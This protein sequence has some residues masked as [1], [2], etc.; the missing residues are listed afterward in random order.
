MS[1]RPTYRFRLSAAGPVQSIALDMATLQSSVMAVLWGP[2][3]TFRLQPVASQVVPVPIVGVG[4]APQRIGRDKPWRVLVSF[5]EP[6]RPEHGRRPVR[7]L[8]YILNDIP[9][10]KWGFLDS[11]QRAS[12]MHK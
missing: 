12:G 4:I 6:H 10:A 7:R 1:W 9:F 5:N 11:G 3:V 8:Q 2:I